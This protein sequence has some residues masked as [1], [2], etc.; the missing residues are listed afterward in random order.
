LRSEYVELKRRA[1]YKDHQH[2]ME[3]YLLCE[4]ENRFS[5]EGGYCAVRIIASE[6]EIVKQ[7]EVRPEGEVNTRSLQNPRIRAT[8]RPMGVTSALKTVTIRRV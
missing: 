2:S 5:G 8:R 3:R 1:L 7:G 4:I 6:G